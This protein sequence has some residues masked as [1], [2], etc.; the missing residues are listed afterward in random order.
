MNIKD[1]IEQAF[2]KQGYDDIINDILCAEIYLYDYP[3]LELAVG[4]NEEK[5]LNV[6]SKFELDVYNVCGVGSRV[7]TVH[8][9]L[10]ILQ[11]YDGSPYW[12]HINPYPPE[13]MDPTNV[14]GR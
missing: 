8:D 3:C 12:K 9:D 10:F 13:H 4:G 6:A 5:F 2:A 14:W 11:E 1:S 7:W